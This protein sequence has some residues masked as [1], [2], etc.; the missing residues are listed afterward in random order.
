M[1]Q[2][3]QEWFEAR[4]GKVTASRVSDVLATRKGQ[5]STVR[6]KYKLQLATERLTNK[7]TD[8][9][10][11]QAMQ[12]GIEREPMAREIYEKLKDVTVEEVGFVQHPAIE[13]AGASPD[14]LVGDDGII[15]I[16]CPIETTHTTNLLERKLPS[17]YKP[18][19]QFQLSTTGRKWCDFISYNP[20]FE[21][22]LQLMVVRVERDDEYI[23]MLKFEILKF[24]AEVELMINQLKEI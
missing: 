6:A 7:K 13:R 12:D 22:R 17:K 15:E 2:L 9:Y 3:S 14:G 18:Q 24:L 16:K 19:V 11:N 8:T 21:P 10:M 23:E 5:E 1:E 4:L 20:N